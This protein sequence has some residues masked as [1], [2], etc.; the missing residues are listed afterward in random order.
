MSCEVEYN[1]YKYILLDYSLFF[2]H[3]QYIVYVSE[4]PTLPSHYIK[5][6]CKCKC[7]CTCMKMNF[8]NIIILFS[9][10]AQILHN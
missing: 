9:A 3:L 6:T 8:T 2:S 4:T 10:I 5:A 7:T 1:N